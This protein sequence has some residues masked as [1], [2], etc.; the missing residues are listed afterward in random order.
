MGLDKDEGYK[1]NCGLDTNNEEKRVLHDTGRH[2]EGNEDGGGGGSE[3]KGVR[4][5]KRMMMPHT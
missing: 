4:K 3:E 1:I 5:R 2:E